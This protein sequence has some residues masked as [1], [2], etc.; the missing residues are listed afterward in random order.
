MSAGATILVVDDEPKIVELLTRG[1]EQ[2]AY[3]VLTAGDGEEAWRQALNDQPDLILLDVLMPKLSGFE[4][5]RRLKEH[6]QTRHIPVVM[7]TA[8]GD[9]SAIFK[10]QELQATDYLTKPFE[11]VKLARLLRRH[12]G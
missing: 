1:L 11:F 8:K 9:T 6:E 2:R 10:A 4:L 3:R 5:L 12:L 7:L